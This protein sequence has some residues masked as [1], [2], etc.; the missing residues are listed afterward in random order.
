MLFCRSSKPT[1]DLKVFLGKAWTTKKYWLSDKLLF[2]WQE[3]KGGQ[4]NPNWAA[5]E[6]S[7][8]IFNYLGR[9]NSPQPGSNCGSFPPLSPTEKHTSSSLHIPSLTSSPATATTKHIHLSFSN[10]LHKTHRRRT[11][12]KVKPVLASTGW[13][14]G[15]RCCWE[16]LAPHTPLMNSTGLAGRS[17]HCLVWTWNSSTP[18]SSREKGQANPSIP[19]GHLWHHITPDHHCWHTAVLEW[20]TCKISVSGGS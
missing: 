14:E 8:G 4:Q 17:K 16:G 3:L 7:P 1:E 19:Q 15:D 13:P 11:W 10:C 9:A 6:G 20:M 18:S 5:A 2:F 12:G